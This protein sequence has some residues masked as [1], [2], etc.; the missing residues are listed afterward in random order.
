MK[1]LKHTILFLFLIAVQ[2]FCGVG[3]AFA[4]NYSRYTNLPTIYIKTFDGKGITSKTVYKYADLY[5]VNEG[6]TVTLY[7]S[8]QIRGR[9]NSTWNMSK[10]PYRIKFKEKEKFLGKGKAKTKKWTLMANA[11]DKTMIR[12]AITSIMGEY[13]GLP[14]NPAY[15]FVDLNINNTYYGTYQ[16]SD[17]VDVRPHRVDVEEQ[18]VPLT[19]E[20]DITGGYLLEVDGFSDGN[21]FTSSKGLPIRIHYPDEED[22]VGE[23]NNYIKSYINNFEKV[24][25]GSNFSDAEQGYRPLVDTTTLVNWFIATEVSANIDG[26]YSTYFYKKRQDPKLYFGPLWDY[27]VAYGNDSRKG[28]TRLKLMTDDGYGQTRVWMNRMWEDPWFCQIVNRRYK[29]VIDAGLT[30]RLLSAIDSLTTLLQRSQQRNYEKWGINTRMYHERVLYSSY[31]QYVDDLREF[32][33][34]HNDWLL[35]T[36]DHKAPAEPTPPFEALNFWYR[37]TNANNAKAIDLVNQSVS[38]DTNICLWE[39]NADRTSQE[40]QIT[41]VSGEYFMLINHLS[42][43]ALNDPTEG[44][45]TATTNVGTVLNVASPNKNADSQLWKFTPQGTDGYYN[46]VNKRT[47]HA[48]NL[49]GG[50]SSNGTSI[51]SYTSDQRNSSSMNRLWYIIPDNEIE[52]EIADAIEVPEPDDYA[53]AFN[54]SNGV[55]HFGSETPDMLRFMVHVYS[56]NGALVGQFRADEQWSTSRLPHGTYLVRWNA[57][58]KTRSTKFIK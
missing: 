9:G 45:A 40:W 22:I 15:K 41:P 10:K 52:P 47:Q 57:G 55:L 31:N 27:D 48:A 36:F 53:L 28:D 25:F 26:Y 8:I 13:L 54:A 2:M 21:C 43:M 42:G 38:S 20:S 6:D 11:G 50:G 4:Q 44:A 5:Y 3:E 23:Q 37:I 16:I 33:T 32:I 17:H 58:G 30:D 14:F 12:N 46:L 56:S 35:S 51:L 1:T 7:D 24:L 18:D 34:T 49:S 39:N 19:E 29:E